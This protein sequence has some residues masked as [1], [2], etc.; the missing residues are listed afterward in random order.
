MDIGLPLKD[1]G[2]VDMN[3]L[4]D[5][6]LSLDE[7]AWNSNTYRQNEYKQ[8]RSTRSLVLL[9]TDS[10][11]WPDIEVTQENGWDL[12]SDVAVPIMDKILAEFYPKGGNIIRAMVANLPAGE[13]IT[14]HVDGHPS[15]HAG[16]R[17]HIPITTN[18]RVRFMVSGN[19]FVCF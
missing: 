1:L 11:G 7:S 3:D 2:S 19:G 18:H 4:R 14:T 13:V 15:F 8:H 9:F 5:A 6:I 10:E 12:L 17:I 16:H